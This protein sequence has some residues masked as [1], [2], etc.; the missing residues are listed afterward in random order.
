MKLFQLFLFVLFLTGCNRLEDK[1]NSFW[2]LWYDKPA[3]EWTEALPLG[4]G[5][6]GAMVFGGTEKEQIQ[7]NEE[8]LWTGEPHNYANEGAWQYLEQIRNLLNQ[9]KQQ[10]A[11]NLAMENFMSIP[12][13]QKA[14]QPF[15]DLLITF[16][17]HKGATGYY[18]ELNLSTAKVNVSYLLDGVKF[19]RSYFVSQPDQVLVAGFSADK[20][21]SLSFNVALTAEHKNYQTEIINGNELS[22]TVKVENGA[23]EGYALLKIIQEDGEISVENNKIIVKNATSALLTLTAATNFENPKELTADPHQKCREIIDLI[24]STD[25]YNEFEKRHL[26]EY[27]SYFNRFDLSFGGAENDTIPTDRR[28]INKLKT[29]DP[30][31][32]ALYVQ[33]GR[34]LLIASSR[35]NTYPANLQG[36]WNKDLSP[37]WDSKYTVNINTQMN[38]W[39]AEVLNLPELHDPLFTLIDEVAASGEIT[40]KEHYNLP[41][42]VLHH[43]TDQWRGTAPINHANH[44]IW[45][46]G[47][48]WLCHHIWEHYLY[49]LDTDFLFEKYPVLRDAAL[50]FRDFLILDEETGWFISSPSNSPETGGLVAGPTMDHSIIRS[51]FEIVVKASEIL[52]TDK[53]FAGQLNEMIPQI[54]PYQIGKYGQLQEWLEDK[55]DPQNKHRHVSHLWAVHPG[56][57]INW[58]ETPELMEAARQSL[59]FRGDEGTGWSLAWKINFWARFKDG[60]HAWTM[61]NTLLQPAEYPGRDI[62][63]GSYPNLFD[64]HPP[65]Q[66][67]GNF[68]GAAGIMEM[69][70]HSHLDGIELLPALPDELSLGWVKGVRARGG[71]ELEFSWENGE[72]LHVNVLSLAGEPLKIVNGNNLLEMN[73]REGQRLKFDGMLQQL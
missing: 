5:R 37:S 21:S 32:A 22:L 51:L 33:F 49:N 10:E 48:A 7:F 60:N 61:V 31:L 12:L 67:D 25:R 27:Q 4:N 6:I 47:G 28:I 11:T 56:N 13:R 45:P 8:T 43:N 58:K 9:C 50:F 3:S 35:P 42:W 34:Y 14:Y 57:E 54:A 24:N 36:I 30:H 71:F 72:L 62:R 64:A 20:K 16:P 46:T 23:M 26:A 59:I 38:Y 44:G 41:G 73:T 65:F 40:A 1:N 52:Q 68:G 18:R 66:I 17:G 29:S 63:G 53:E 69:L 39:P 55:D 19:K 15:G 2:K 70:M